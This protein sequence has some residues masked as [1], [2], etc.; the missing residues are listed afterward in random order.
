MSAF[1]GGFKVEGAA[2][3]GLG[4]GAEAEYVDSVTVAF[5]NVQIEQ[6]PI[7]DLEGVVQT[8]GPKCRE[9]LERFRKQNI[10]YQTVQALRADVTYNAAFKSGASAGIKNAVITKLKLG[11]GGNTQNS[12]E[13]SVSGKGLYYG[14]DIQ[15]I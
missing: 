3:K 8:L 10:A 13:V 5:T 12:G 7:A 14:L 1:S 11:L 9:T 4:L 15:K 2:L 6:L